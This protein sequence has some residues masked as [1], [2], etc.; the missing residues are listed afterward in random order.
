MVTSIVGLN[1]KRLDFPQFLELMW[2]AWEHNVGNLSK[3]LGKRSIFDLPRR[4][5]DSMASEPKARKSMA[6]IQS[7]SIGGGRKSVASILK[8]QGNKLEV[9][10]RLTAC[11]DEDSDGDQESDAEDDGEDMVECNTTLQELRWSRIE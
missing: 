5:M 6:L 7:M 9:Q 4:T 3:T 1:G 10:R 8:D 2:E 11:Q